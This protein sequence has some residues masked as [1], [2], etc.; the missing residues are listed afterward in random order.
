MNDIPFL[1]PND[2][3]TWLLKIP[4]LLIWLNPDQQALRWQF[5]SLSDAML[6]M[7]RGTSDRSS[8]EQ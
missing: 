1:N 3:L 8:K 6:M 4:V 2:S 7:Q 5:C